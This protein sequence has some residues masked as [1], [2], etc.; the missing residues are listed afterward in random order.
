MSESGNE[1]RERHTEKLI[2]RNRAIR[3]LAEHLAYNQAGK[4]VAL[5]QEKTIKTPIGWGEEWVRLRNAFLI[6]GYPSVEE[7]EEQIR[8]V[9]MIEL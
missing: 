8:R 4:S 9:L 5:Q 6:F 3:Q 7:C 2:A 1:K